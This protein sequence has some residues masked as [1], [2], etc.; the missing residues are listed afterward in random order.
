MSG[1]QSGGSRALAT[2]DSQP[3]WQARVVR[4][5]AYLV[6]VKSREVRIIRDR[7][8]WWIEVALIRGDRRLPLDVLNA[9]RLDSAWEPPAH[10][11]AGSPLATQLPD[12]LAWAQTLPAV[13]GW[14]DQPG[15]EDLARAA[16]VSAQASR[17]S[18]PNV[19]T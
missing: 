6:F 1:Q 14:L 16:A 17:R 3:R 8:Q 12:G 4:Q 2:A 18:K 19:K 7:S 10:R 5:C 11:P 9:A 15:A 13:L